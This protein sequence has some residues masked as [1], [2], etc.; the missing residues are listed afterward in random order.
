MA[1]LLRIGI[2]RVV[3]KRCMQAVTLTSLVS[4]ENLSTYRIVGAHVVATDD[5]IL[6]CPRLFPLLLQKAMK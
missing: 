4:D 2:M 1:Y 6:Q 3:K 5:L